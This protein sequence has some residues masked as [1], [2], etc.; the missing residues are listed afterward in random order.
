MIQHRNYCQSEK[1][2]TH[3]T[4]PLHHCPPQMDS[5]A[6]ILRTDHH[7]RACCGESRHCFK[8]SVANRRLRRTENERQHTEYGKNHPDRGRQKIAVATPEVLEARFRTASHNRPAEQGKT[9]NNKKRQIV[10]FAIESRC[11]RRE[12]HENAFYAQ[13]PSEY[14]HQ[15]PEINQRPVL[16]LP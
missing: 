6:Q 11:S 10:A 12:K 16:D 7:R 13:K 9:C 8:K 1:D 5:M 2:Y 4:D 3:S 15:H 14:T